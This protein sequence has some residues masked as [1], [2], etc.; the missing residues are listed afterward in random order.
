MRC[1]SALWHI[2][3]L[4]PPTAQGRRLHEA[5]H[6]Y[7]SGSASQTHHTFASAPLHAQ[8]CC[9]LHV[10]HTPNNTCCAH[11]TN[12]PTGHCVQ[13]ASRLHSLQL[14]MQSTPHIL[15]CNHCVN[16]A[17]S[18][19]TPA[20]LLPHP[21]E[22]QRGLPAQRTAAGSWAAHAQHAAGRLLPGPH[23]PQCLPASGHNHTTP[24]QGREGTCTRGLC[25]IRWIRE[26]CWECT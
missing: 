22:P 14:N 21:L 2:Q 24:A 10:H 16:T 5:P 9:C 11:S 3:V 12:Q 7:C 4:P 6:V 1:G 25:Q 8:H 18:T 26:L 20:W 13:S 23:H 17:R 19:H 15:N